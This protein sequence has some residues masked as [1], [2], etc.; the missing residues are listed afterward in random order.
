MLFTR[1]TSGHGGPYKVI[2]YFVGL[3]E[4]PL[5]S[6]AFFK[7]TNYTLLNILFITHIIQAL[8]LFNVNVM[9][10]IHIKN[11]NSGSNGII[12]YKV[13]IS[14]KIFVRSSAGYSELSSRLEEVQYELVNRL[15]RYLTDQ[16]TETAPH[17]QPYHLTSNASAGTESNRTSSSTDTIT[18]AT[19]SAAVATLNLPIGS[20]SI[21]D[22]ISS[23]LSALDDITNP[24]FHNINNNNNNNISNK[25][26]KL[27]HLQPHL[28]SSH[29][30]TT[31]QARKARSKLISMP[32]VLLEELAA[33]LYDEVS[34]DCGLDVKRT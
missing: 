30:H 19:N 16:H 29:E 11:N 12:N 28:I 22:E 25:E 8:R 32:S 26:T 3:R 7:L 33:D 24:S 21:N 13:A 18:G 17:T 9:L 14:C 27:C 15:I 2:S 4:N 20:I 5:K 34:R 6:R 1:V 31:E 23:T 10:F